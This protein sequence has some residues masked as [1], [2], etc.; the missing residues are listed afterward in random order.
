MVKISKVIKKKSIK[1]QK[2]VYT[3]ICLILNKKARSTRMIQ[4]N[5]VSGLLLKG[6]FVVGNHSFKLLVFK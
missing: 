2:K 4:M 3:K 5:N 1:K 6:E